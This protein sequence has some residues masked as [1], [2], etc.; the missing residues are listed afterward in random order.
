MARRRRNPEQQSNRVAVGQPAALDAL[1]VGG[2]P[3]LNHDTPTDEPIHPGR[4]RVPRRAIRKRV[5]KDGDHVLMA[6]SDGTTA[7]KNSLLWI[8]GVP[9]FSHRLL[10]DRWLKR[11]DHRALLV[12]YARIAQVRFVNV[13]QP[14]EQARRSVTLN[15]SRKHM[16]NEPEAEDE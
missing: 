6:V 10:L 4:N 1:P 15:T 2:A 13:Y 7:P 11:T 12:P 9:K 16:V 8:P 5:F 3:S 14:T